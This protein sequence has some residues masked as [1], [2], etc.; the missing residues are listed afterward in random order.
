[1]QPNGGHV[2]C[3]DGAAHPSNHVNLTNDTL[4]S[5]DDGLI[6]HAEVAAADPDVV[7]LHGPHVVRIWGQPLVR[8][9]GLCVRAVRPLPLA[10]HYLVRGPNPLFPR[11]DAYTKENRIAYSEPGADSACSGSCPLWR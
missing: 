8:Q 2:T 10:V 3:T 4:A 9:H 6:V 5:V 7:F 11:D 1:M